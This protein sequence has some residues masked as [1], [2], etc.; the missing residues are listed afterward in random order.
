MVAPLTE[1]PLFDLLCRKR[2]DG[3]YFSHYFDHDIGHRSGQRNLLCI[4]MEAPEEIRD[5][6]K[7]ASKRIVAC[8][9]TSS[10][11]T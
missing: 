7:E 10:S 4:N 6:F 11:L 8:A 5:A 3:E 1:P 2:K 9:D